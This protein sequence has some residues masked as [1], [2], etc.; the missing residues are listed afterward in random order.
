[1]TSDRKKQIN[2]K[3]KHLNKVREQALRKSGE[4]LYK[5]NKQWVKIVS[6]KALG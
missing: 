2:K 1:M 5:Q 4:E 3:K 6:S